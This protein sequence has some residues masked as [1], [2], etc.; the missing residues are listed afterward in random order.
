MH[1]GNKLLFE[2]KIYII[3]QLKKKK[4]Q[5]PESKRSIY[6]HCSSQLIEFT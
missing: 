1:K 2:N 4:T 6:V 3:K 5:R